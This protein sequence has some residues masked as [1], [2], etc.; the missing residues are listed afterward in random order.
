[1]SVVAGAFG[2]LTAQWGIDA[3]IRLAPNNLPQIEE[4]TLNTTV[5]AFAL[6]VVAIIAV[7]SGLAPAFRLAGVPV[8]APLNEGG[9][10]QSGAA[11]GWS[12]SALLVVEVGL[13]LLLLFGTGLLLRSFHELRAVDL[14]FNKRCARET[15]RFRGPELRPS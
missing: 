13:S 14:G 8:S 6:G 4:V 3:L 1:M 9:R 11:K 12:H 5:L 7:L 2:L 10:G 15:G